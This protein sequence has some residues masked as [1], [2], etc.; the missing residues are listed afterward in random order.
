MLRGSGDLTALPDEVT[1]SVGT[2]WRLGTALAYPLGTG[3]NAL[4]RS[5][6]AGSWVRMNEDHRVLPQ[7]KKKVQLEIKRVP[8]SRDDAAVGQEITKN[9]L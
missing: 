4:P 3:S 6:S 2:C 9:K 7:K 8:S 5:H 1:G